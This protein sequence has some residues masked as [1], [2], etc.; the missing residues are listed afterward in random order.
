VLSSWAG[1]SAPTRSARTP[2]G[3]QA[4]ADLNLLP[5]HGKVLGLDAA[6]AR[7]PSLSRGQHGQT[8]TFN[9]A[10]CAGGVG[11]A[12]KFLSPGTCPGCHFC[13]TLQDLPGALLTRK[14]APPRAPPS[15]M[16]RYASPARTPRRGAAP[17]WRCCCLR[18]YTFPL[19]IQRYSCSAFLYASTFITLRT[20][21]PAAYATNGNIA[22][23]EQRPANTHDYELARYRARWAAAGARLHACQPPSLPF[24]S[25][26]PSQ[27]G[28]TFYQCSSHFLILPLLPLLR[29]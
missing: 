20:A 22:G 2:P 15:A 23:F 4:H 24:T 12:G 8:W 26:H 25:P 17:A 6:V 28:H 11:Q 16:L 1:D 9:G 14:Q 29:W 13:G 3:R 27:C 10:F 21:R 19:S 7:S 5:L 18:L